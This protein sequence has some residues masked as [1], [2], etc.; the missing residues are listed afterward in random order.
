ME[1]EAGYAGYERFGVSED[2]DEGQSE[3]SL[4]ECQELLGEVSAKENGEPI[5]DVVHKSLSKFPPDTT[6]NYANGAA[7]EICL[8]VTASIG[9]SIKKDPDDGMVAANEVT[10]EKTRF[11]GSN[12]ESDEPMEEM[13]ESLSKFPPD[14]TEDCPNEPDAVEIST[15][16]TASVE[17][18]IKKAP[19]DE[20]VAANDELARQRLNSTSKIGSKQLDEFDSAEVKTCSKKKAPDEPPKAGTL[21]YC[22]SGST[23][24]LG[25]LVTA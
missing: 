21:L 12:E 7:M 1:E 13:H 20:G 4:E 24:A 6:E 11:H 22:S 25:W 2:E 3:W 15:R 9:V 5:E 8:R 19:G 23:T 10:A 17:L 16:D 14:T 18:L